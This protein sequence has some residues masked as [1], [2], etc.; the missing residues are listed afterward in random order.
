M[1]DDYR[2]FQIEPVDIKAVKEVLDGFSDPF[3]TVD[4]VEL[5]N[6][7]SHFRDDVQVPPSQN[8]H[9]FCETV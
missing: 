2:E 3:R 1:Y 9:C 4:T 7:L 8:V 6:C 5:E